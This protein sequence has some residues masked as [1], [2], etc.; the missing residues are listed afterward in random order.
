MAREQRKDVDYFPHECTHGR[1]MHII[2]DRYGNDG[3]ATWFKLLE[4]L[5]KAN[6]H[7]IDVSD[8]MTQMFLSSIFKIDIELMM[9][10]FSDLSKLK[11]IDKY[12][13]ETY[14]VI[15][16]QKFCDSILDAYRKRKSEMI[17]YSAILAKMQSKNTQSSGGLTSKSHIPPQCSGIKVEVIP[18]EEKS[19][20][21]YSKEEKRKEKNIFNFRKKLIEYGFKENLVK[22]WLVVRKNKKATNTETAYNSFI[23]EIESRDCDC[24]DMLAECVKNSWAGFKHSW[25]DNINKKANENTNSSTGTGKNTG[26]KPA[27]VNTEKLIRELA[28]DAENGNIP[29]VYQ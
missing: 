27:T 16:S 5:G 10:I 17:Q 13:F 26:Y 7:Y 6:N 15:Y 14:Q 22:E 20:V 2:E 24:N 23:A 28:D 21:E 18:K 4:Q 9:K 19:I 8:E 1:K 29:G 25:I 11:A 12:L 3:Y